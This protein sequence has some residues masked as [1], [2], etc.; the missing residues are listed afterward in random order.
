MNL[1]PCLVVD[2]IEVDVGKEQASAEVRIGPRHKR[3]VI[4]YAYGIWA[5]EEMPSELDRSIR[6]KRAILEAMARAYQGETV[7]LPMDL[8]DTVR[9]IDEPWPFWMKAE[10]RPSDP[11]AIEVTKVE[12]NTPKRKMTTV[13]MQVLEIPTV[14]IADNRY[15]PREWTRLRFVSG[16]HPWQLTD[17]EAWAM[18]LALDNTVPGGIEG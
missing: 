15:V 2:A 3:I 6:P 5:Y 1:P 13:H 4:D 14:V 16:V 11:V 9:D 12:H 18:L 7:S 10:H 17:A 8:S